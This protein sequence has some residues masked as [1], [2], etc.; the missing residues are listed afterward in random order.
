MSQGIKP[1][2]AVWRKRLLREL[3]Y[4]DQ[5][6]CQSILSWLVTHESEHKLAP[7]ELATVNERLNYRYRILRQRYLYVDSNQA[8]RQL[9]TRLGSVVL[10]IAPVQTWIKRHS[11]SHQETLRLIHKV[12]QELL[13]ND[14]HVQQK[15]DQILRCT[16]D[17]HLRKALVLATVEEYCMSTVQNQPLL[18]HLLRQYLQC[19]LQ[20]ENYQ[21]A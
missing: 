12:V 14:L 3:P 16:T 8:Y 2:K 10:G 11:T 18:I 19:Q 6:K 5:Q 17:P 15:I 21:A 20:S 7:H 1:L 13:D 4:S 9:I